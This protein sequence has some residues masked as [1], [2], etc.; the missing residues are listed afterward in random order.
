MGLDAVKVKQLIKNIVELQKELKLLTRKIEKL[1]ADS[2]KTSNKGG[3]TFK[4]DC[5]IAKLTAEFEHLDEEVRGL[6]KA[7]RNSWV[8]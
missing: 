7:A 8:D 5:D 4:I 2:L 1:K 6:Y 3:D